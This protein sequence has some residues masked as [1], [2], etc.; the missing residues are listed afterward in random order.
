MSL[1]S[2]LGKLERRCSAGNLD[3]SKLSD[4]ELD[5][6]LRKS[7]YDELDVLLRKCVEQLG[8]DWASFQIDPT[9]VI[10]K[11]FEGVEDEDGAI[12]R[13]SKAIAEAGTDWLR[14]EPSPP[15][16]W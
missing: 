11:T 6:L 5:V 3:P 16:G 15:V 8:I 2:R 10:E 7:S 12:A 13:L 1:K 4:A 14:P 9:G